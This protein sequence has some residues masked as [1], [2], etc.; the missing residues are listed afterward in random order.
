[1]AAPRDPLKC[2]CGNTTAVLQ[3]C[4]YR[5]TS[6]SDLERVQFRSAKMDGS[7]LCN[8]GCLTT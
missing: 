8:D 6:R 2:S 4:S 5:N 7:I 1:M 3:K